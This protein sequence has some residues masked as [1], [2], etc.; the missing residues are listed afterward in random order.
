[1]KNVFRI[2]NVIEKCLLSLI[3]LQSTNSIIA[4]TKKE[5]FQISSA[6][7]GLQRSGNG[8]GLLFTGGLNYDFK[9]HL[10]NTSVIIPKRNGEIKGGKI[11]YSYVLVKNE[12]DERV[13][14][15]DKSGVICDPVF[16]LS[17][18]ISGL[19]MHQA[20]LSYNTVKLENWIN[21]VEGMNW[22][23]VRYKTIEVSAGFNLDLNVCK[24]VTI[25][26]SIGTGLYHRLNHIKNAHFENNQIT[27]Q[28]STGLVLNIK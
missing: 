4:Q 27:I 5:R 20:P 18:F 23:T 25:R 16:G 9:R 2:N 3:M 24:R 10:I 1:M 13:I 6:E 14:A 7:V 21:R 19:Y 8:H 26:N 15:R 17:C 11:K 22:E 12:S 28:L